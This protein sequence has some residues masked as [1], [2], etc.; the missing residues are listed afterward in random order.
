MLVI[1]SFILFYFQLNAQKVREDNFRP[2]RGK[3]AE[4]LESVTKLTEFGLPMSSSKT[5]YKDEASVPLIN[6]D[7]NG[8]VNGRWDVGLFDCFDNCIPNRKCSM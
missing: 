7:H 3:L 6:V 5:N 4:R 1:T 2:S 8:I